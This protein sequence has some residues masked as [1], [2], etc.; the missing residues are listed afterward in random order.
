MAGGKKIQAKI[1]PQEQ[2][3]EKTLLNEIKIK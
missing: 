1:L 2:G 3:F